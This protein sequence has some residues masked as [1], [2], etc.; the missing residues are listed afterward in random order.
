MA[1]VLKSSF[2]KYIMEAADL[3][4]ERTCYKSIQIE[5]IFI[6]IAD[7]LN[8][9]YNSAITGY[10]AADFEKESAECRKLF[11]QFGINA[12]NI[13]SRISK[14]LDEHK[15]TVSQGYMAQRIIYSA[16]DTAT[17]SG[18]EEVT[19][20]ILL[21]KIIESPSQLM[22]DAGFLTQTIEENT[23]D[24][25]SLLKAIQNRSVE[26]KQEKEKKTESDEAPVQTEEAPKPREPEH[27][28]ERI[29]QLTKESKEIRDKLRKMIFGQDNAINVFASGY[30]QSEMRAFVQKQNNKPAATFLFVGPPGVGK[31]FLSE[32][33]ADI[34]DRPY[35]R[36]NMSEYSD[37][38]AN[39]AFCGS[40]K[41]YK[42]GS[43]GNVTEFV[44]NNP[45][46][47]LLFDEIEKAHINVIHLFLQIL[48][49]GV[50][51]DNYTEKNVSFAD[52]IIIFTTNAGKNLYNTLEENNTLIP[53]KTILHA[54]E[55]DIN[56]ET[57]T[58]Y[59]PAAICSRFAS[60]NVVMFNQIEAHDLLKIAK[61]EIVCYSE[62]FGSMFDINTEI[63][64]KVYTS[65]LFALGGKADA[66]TVKSR[67]H[68]FYSDELYEL[69][70][71]VDADE[72]SIDSIN[73]IRFDVQLPSDNDK[74]S[75]LFKNKYTPEILVFAD[76]N[77][78]DIIS[79]SDKYVVHY[80]DSLEEAEEILVKNDITLIFCD[81]TFRTRD[82]NS[83]FLNIEDI[84]S[85][86]RDFF[87]HI[88]AGPIS[89]P[90][91]IL[92][93]ESRPL[94]NEEKF[95]F[96]KNGA[97]D[98]IRVEETI[99]DRIMDICDKLYQQKSLIN[100]AKA[101]KVI[102]FETA[103][104]ISEDR[105]EAVITLFD[106]KMNTSV[107]AEDSFGVL[108]D[109]SKPDV[110]FDDVIG[111]KD[112]IEEL[113]YFVEYLKEPKKFFKKGVGAPKG[114]L[115]HGEPGT[116]KTM[117]AK[118]MACEAD[119][120][121]IAVEG[122]QFLK[123]YVGEGPQLV[124]DI[125][126][127]ARKYAPSIIFVDE[128]DAIGRERTDSHH[129]QIISDVLNAFLAEMDGFK[130]DV[131]K[132][133][134]VLAATNFEVEPGRAKSLDPALMRRFD[135][136]IY[137]DLPNKE[138]RIRFITTAIKKNSIIN[139]TEEKIENIAVR[140]TGMSL[141]QLASVIELALRNTVRSGKDEMSDE[142]FDEAYETFNN[143]E[144]KKWESSLLERTARHESGHVLMC[145]EA[146][147]KPSYV[148][149]TARSDHGGY[150]QHA[151]NEGKAL[152]TRNE[153]LGRIR[154]SLGG[155]AAEIVYY[156]EED[157]VSTGAS[158]DLV[159]AT[160]VARKIITTYGMDEE[161]GLA[162]Y[163]GNLNGN[164]EKL[165]N[166]INEIL[167]REL[168]V[169]IETISEKRRI[170]DALVAELMEKN[171]LTGDEIYTIYKNNL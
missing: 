78:R 59:F 110:H 162:S 116:G 83:D 70:R 13:A 48:D 136:R 115:L 67:A 137:V 157:G 21:K 29:K 1:E 109:S 10:E 168:K 61:K 47:L 60:G 56:P 123:K 30:F 146:G 32:Q 63:D 51:R 5:H 160:S 117:L 7:H 99:C 145:L 118:A 66:R 140:S 82:N 120:T 8:Y 58:A 133:V 135:R 147:E 93:S 97:R 11:D 108:N 37:K 38:E 169:A 148:T 14:L 104:T 122:N 25:Q 153:L 75:S 64:E 130:N 22:R 17:K 124:H 107:D 55:T 62:A 101:N 164:D 151:D 131:S 96:V 3:V 163:D 16:N 159:S 43:P 27:G 141:A 72:I 155:R 36:F 139:I 89:S 143:G 166:R 52:A 40:D 42:N 100:L 134:F 149:I 79:K 127:K 84:D 49:A 95:S 91:Y 144:A 54:L 31:T 114:V 71:L 129:S 68:T 57:G 77:A 74:I 113:K 4:K 158:G 69:F 161:F 102:A 34:L 45:R 28:K 128:I 35:C 76:S 138:E 142:M 132:P 73:K 80:A 9:G 2:Y 88:I 106:F 53:R 94:N 33:V 86:G 167:G 41:V 156:G 152:Y 46:C 92:E 65:I 18:L 50:V 171:H 23:T 20:D 26:R 12:K 15:P 44:Q 103:Q 112:A 126:A 165:R 6:A 24:V 150:M 170:I 111:A 81:I 125:F 105:S 87:R 119:A 39:L 85:L 154:T 90:V 19:V 121:F 98:T